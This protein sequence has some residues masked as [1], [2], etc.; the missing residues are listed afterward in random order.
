LGV[1]FGVSKNSAAVGE[2][3]AYLLTYLLYGTESFLKS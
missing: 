3:Y 2:R 1:T